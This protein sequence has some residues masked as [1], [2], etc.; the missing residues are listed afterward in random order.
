MAAMVIDMNET[1]L[2]ALEQLKAFLQGTGGGRAPALRRAL[3]TPPGGAQALWL[4]KAQAG[5]QGSINAFCAAHLNLY[6]NFHRPCLFA[7]NVLDAKG[8]R[9]KRYPQR[10][11]MTPLEKLA[12]LPDTDSFLKPGVTLAQLQTEATRLTDN[13]AAQQLNE[14][15][16]RLF[17]S[18]HPRPKCAACSAELTWGTTTP[19]APIS[20]AFLIQTSSAA[21]TRSTGSERPPIACK[22]RNAPSLPIGPCS[23][24]M[25][26]QS[27][28]TSARSSATSGDDA[29]ESFGGQRSHRISTRRSPDP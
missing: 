19:T 20:R 11:V 27:K 28:P 10:L 29:L 14:A 8:K 25:N 7:E 13:E 4:C 2:C 1:P 9:K 17:Q 5:R 6:L 15:K 26:S 3:R 12:S 23:A 24:S 18:I 16:R 22:S 21:G